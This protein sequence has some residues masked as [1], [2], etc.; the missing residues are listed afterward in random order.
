MVVSRSQVL[1][2][3]AKDMGLRVD[4]R[5]VEYAEVESFKE[6]A[7]CGTA[8]V[9]TPIKSLTRNGKVRG[10]CRPAALLPMLLLLRLLRS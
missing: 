8:V 6:V 2:Q 1:Q 7:A 3:L 9:I 5:P 10:D 4:V